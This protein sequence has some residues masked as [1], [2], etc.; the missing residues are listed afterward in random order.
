MAFGK[1]GYRRLVVRGRVFFWR[2]DCQDPVIRL[3]LA[4]STGAGDRHDPPHVDRVLIR[5]EDQPHRVLRVDCGF[6]CPLVTPAA[7]RKW[8]EAALVLG[9]PDRRDSLELNGLLV[10]GPVPSD[11]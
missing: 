2:Y 9:W 10:P 8:L 3:A 1:K 6:T 7:V 4:A 5:P 11:P